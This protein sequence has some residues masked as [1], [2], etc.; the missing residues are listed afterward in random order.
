MKPCAV[1]R[2]PTD[3]R[4]TYDMDSLGT[5]V[6]SDDCKWML[7]SKLADTIRRERDANEVPP[8]PRMDALRD[9]S[10]SGGDG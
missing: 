2:K 7:L 9:R 10:G 4:L 6:C 5:P 3:Q 8:L 1:C